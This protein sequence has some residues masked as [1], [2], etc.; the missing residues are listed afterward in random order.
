MTK[1]QTVI[2]TTDGLDE[3]IANFYT[4]NDGKYVLA[5]EGVDAH[6]EVANLKSAYERVKADIKTTKAER[7]ALKAKVSNLPEDFDPAKWDKLKDG[8]ADEAAQI[9]LRDEYEARIADLTGKLTATQEAVRKTAI[10]RDL[11]D[12]LTG[13][14]F[15]D[16]AILDLARTKLAN[17][18]KIDENG[19]PY[20][21]TDMGPISPQDR[22]V[23]LANG[24]WK[25]LVT[26][27]KGGGS[28]SGSDT[29]AKPSGNLGGSKADRLAAI[30]NR[31]PDL[32]G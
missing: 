31:F 23:R 6:P 27:P 2:D 30:A 29:V 20:I 21:E 4:E 13:A 17:E 8:K 18:V 19:K 7:D 16:P 9:K 22:A 5:I 24:E 15:T 11:T 3:A 28:K 12:A 14:G 1:L 32:Q 10:E 26:A 25:G